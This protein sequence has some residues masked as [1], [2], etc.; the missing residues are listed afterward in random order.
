MAVKMPERKYF[1]FPELVR[2][3]E[4]DENDLRRMILDRELIPSYVINEFARV[5]KFKLSSPDVP[6]YESAY[7]ISESVERDKLPGELEE[8]DPVKY[9]LVETDG[10]YYLLH[11]WQTTS[12]NCTFLYF[13]N[14][15][16]HQQESGETCFMLH[17]QEPLSLDEVMKNGVAMADEVFRLERRDTYLLDTS[18]VGKSEI[19]ARE[20]TTYLNII[21]AM[22]ELLQSSKPSRESAAAVIRELVDNYGD[23]PGISKT[24]LELKFAD[25]VRS[26]RAT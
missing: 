8:K 24:N 5:V 20:R 19:G 6:E 9:L 2:R 23:M 11:P 25:A 7:W 22:L 1:T 21:G 14:S 17:R 13:S 15:R 16:S 26:I 3:W 4:C 10:F 12:L 18:N